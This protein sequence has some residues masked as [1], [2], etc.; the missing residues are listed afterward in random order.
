MFASYPRGILASGHVSTE[1]DAEAMFEYIN[2]YVI[3]SPRTA[4]RH[5][6]KINPGEYLTWKDGNARTDRYWEMTY[7]ENAVGPPK[8]LA[9]DCFTSWKNPCG[10]LHEILPQ[11]DRLLPQR[12]D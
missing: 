2:C 7:P 5:I 10:S 9:E 12:R 8:Q 11:H 4:F 1:A 6:V 3:P